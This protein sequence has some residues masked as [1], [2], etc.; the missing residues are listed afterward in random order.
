MAKENV[1]NSP[2]NWAN[3]TGMKR[4]IKTILLSAGLG[5]RMAP[6]TTHHIPKPMFPLGFGVPLIE[7]WIQ[8]SIQSGISD[9]TMNLCV[10]GNTIREYFKDGSHLGASIS[11]AEEDI[12]GGTFGGVCKMVMGNTTPPVYPGEKIPQIL[13]FNG[14]TVFVISGDIVSN[15]DAEQLEELY[16]IH[17]QKGAAFTMILTP[18]PWEERGEF[19]T[20][21][22][23]NP[24][25]LS[26]PFSQSGPIIDFREK[27]PNSPSNLN[28]ASIYIIET[29]LIKALL[30]FR[31]PAKPGIQNPF[32]DFGKH[33][34]PAML[35]KLDYIKLPKDFL[36]WGI[37]YD[38]LWFDVGRKRDYLAV[39]NH[40]LEG[41]INTPASCQKEQTGYRLEIDHYLTRYSINGPVLIGN[42][43]V[44]H[45]GMEVGPNVVVGDGWKIGKNVKITNSILWPRYDFYTSND[46]K[47]DSQEWEK[48]DL[49]E[50]ADGVKID[51]AII[52]GGKITEDISG[53]VV[54][55]NESG[56]ILLYDLDWVPDMTRA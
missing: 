1:S 7:Y 8:K 36:L 28:N 11:Y 48:R 31:T 17:K 26:F 54:D 45:D 52:V 38:G 10:L 16:R 39:S 4:N 27:D 53:K 30:P 47:L 29:D 12:P 55:I 41:K 42:D 21:Q 49:H 14:S 35:N 43:C 22:L 51:S 44:I 20:V 56:E 33:V 50:I 15:F 5:S 25:T 9:I 19:G 24:E 46:T 37:Q 23:Q 18:V 2:D 40:V 34:F 32:Y 13:P 6:L 3:H